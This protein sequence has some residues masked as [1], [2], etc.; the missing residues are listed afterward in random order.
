MSASMNHD[1]LTG[2]RTPR[3]VLWLCAL[4]VTAFAAWA[5][6]FSLDV[7]SV[8]GGQ[9]IPSSRVQV[10]QHLEGGIVREIHVREGE[11]VGPGHP[12]VSLEQIQSGAGVE[13]LQSR[14]TGLRVDIAVLEAQAANTTPVFDRDLLD[15]HPELVE[16]AES[17]FRVSVARHQSDISGQTELIRQREHAL[18]E[19]SARVRNARENLKLVEEQVALSEE[20][21]KD[22]LTTQHRH[23]GYLREAGELRGRIEEDE[24]ALAAAR[25]ALNEARVRLE[26]MRNA[27]QEDLESRLKEA[28][29]KKE[30]ASQRL[31]RLAD[32][33]DRTVIRSPVEGIVKTLHVS[34]LGGVVLPGQTVADIVPSEDRLIIEAQLSIRDIG[35]VREGQ[36]AAVRLAGSD[37]AIFG[38]IHGSV[39]H[40]APDTTSVPDGRVFYLV[41]VE[42]EQDYFRSGDARYHLFPGMTMMVYIHTGT[43]TVMQYL[44]EPFTARF[45]GALQER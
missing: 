5:A 1:N 42:T 45:A 23:L 21:L 6:M 24:S 32:S 31:P 12:L 22:N 29:Q 11:R 8:A 37:S 30:E 2:N 3:L 41:R 10:V 40:V 20:L 33:L 39:I 27:Y 19:I 26:R 4:A 15:L 38:K 14:I 16:Q 36:A 44:L 13:E 9:V 35:F 7:V 43:R 34:T 25:S 17:L 18:A 28:R